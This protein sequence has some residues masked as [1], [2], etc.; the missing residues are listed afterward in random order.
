M[1]CPND[2]ECSREIKNK[3]AN[4]ILHWPFKKMTLLYFDYVKTAR[5]FVPGKVCVAQKRV[6]QGTMYVMECKIV[7]KT[8]V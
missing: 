1:V 8:A 2:E 4:W 7:K 3:G 5:F 6:V